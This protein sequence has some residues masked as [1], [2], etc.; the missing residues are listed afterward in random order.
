LFFVERFF[1]SGESIHEERRQ[2]HNW[3]I[4]HYYV[5]ILR[6]KNSFNKKQAHFI[7]SLWASPYRV[8]MLHGSLS[9]GPTLRSG[10]PPY[11]RHHFAALM[12]RDFH[13]LRQNEIRLLFFA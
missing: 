4:R 11:G 13:H 5:L 6:Y 12:Q 8:A 10:L 9:L 1:G 2:D 7:L 3:F